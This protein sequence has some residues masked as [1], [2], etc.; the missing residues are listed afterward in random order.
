MTLAPHQVA[1]AAATRFWAATAWPPASIQS[2]TNST[3]GWQQI[4]PHSELQVAVLALL[5]ALTSQLARALHSCTHPAGHRPLTLSRSEADALALLDERSSR[6]L[7]AD[8]S[9]SY[10]SAHIE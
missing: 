9:R 7:L 8:G 5:V 2:S 4:A 10:Q 1:P 3:P 6:L